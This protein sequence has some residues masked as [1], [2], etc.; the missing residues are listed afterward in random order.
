M[1][2]KKQSKCLLVALSMVFV[3][4]CTPFSGR[5]V[6]PAPLPP[7]QIEGW[8]PVYA[9]P[10]DKNLIGSAEPRNVEKGGKIYVKGRTLFQ[11]EAGKGIHVID[12]TDGN[13]PKNVKFI[14]VT[15]AQEMAV[16]NNNLYTNHINDLVVLNIS[17][18]DNVQ[19]IDRVTGVFHL[20]DAQ[21]PPSNGYFECI[22]AKKGEVIGWELTTLYK[23]LCRKS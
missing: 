13:N 6:E 18:L 15:G 21:A 19:V 14:Q 3:T 4:A 16:M 5:D 7:E 20:V 2:T 22:D 23:P 12:I 11:V 9:S 17:N 1:D 8:K 10:D